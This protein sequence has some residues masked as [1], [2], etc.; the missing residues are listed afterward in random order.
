MRDGEK[1]PVAIE[2]VTCRVQTRMERKRTRPE[3]WLVIT[4]RP[5]TDDRTL[6]ARASRDATDYDARYRYHYYLTPSDGCGVAFQEPSVEELA[7]VITAGACIESS[8]KRGKGEVGMDE[9]QVRTWHGWHH[10]MALS[11]MALWFLIGETHRGQQWTPAL[12]LPQALSS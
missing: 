2:M 1:G 12:P 8:C 4:R 5:V 11:L 9:Y 6:E 10:H 3:E 7:R